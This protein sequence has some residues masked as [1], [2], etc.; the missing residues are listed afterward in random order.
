MDLGQLE[1]CLRLSEA[2]QCWHG[3]NNSTSQGGMPVPA[4]RRV[5]RYLETLPKDMLL[6]EIC[7]TQEGQGSGG[8][9]SSSQIQQL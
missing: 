4:L 3:D 2:A 1:K 5:Q 8:H 9:S 7:Q 6:R